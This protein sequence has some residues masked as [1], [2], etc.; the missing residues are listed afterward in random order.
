M[1]SYKFVAL[2]SAL[3]AGVAAAPVSKRM[4]GQSTFYDPSTG[5]G[6][7]G[8]NNNKNEHV[9]AVT[10]S[11]YAGGSN[12]GKHISITNKKTGTVQSA[13]IADECPT[14][15][16]EQDLDMSPGLF[17]SLGGTE[18]EGVFPISWHFNGKQKRASGQATFYDAGLGACGDTNSASDMIVAVTPSMYGGG[19][20]CGK[21]ISIT[22]QKTG[23]TQQATIKDL[24]PTCGGSQDLDMSK[25]LF[26]ALGGTENEG[27][28][29]I[30]W[31]FGGSSSGSSNNNNNNKQNNNNNNKQNGQNKK[32]ASKSDNSGS[33]SSSSSASPSKTSAA[34]SHSASATGTSTS[35]ASAQATGSNNQ[36]SKDTVSGTPSWWAKVESYCNLDSQPENPV[37]IAG[38]RLWSV[39]D[40]SKACGKAVS[41]KNPS[42][43]KT[44][45]G[46]VVSYLP[47]GEENSIALEDAYKQL[48]GDAGSVDSVQWGFTD[49]N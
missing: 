22:N 42:N 28:F 17:K 27:V 46:T 29:P 33:S 49:S 18:N 25:G 8:W 39:A 47:S 12:C 30:T 5:T 20:N 43:G 11:M 48:A 36:G 35:S 21:Q 24:C 10:P 2:A 15:S 34:T 37:A 23:T 45:Q 16:G 44:V 9:V 7:C 3:V 13:M 38:S 41:V 14:C 31:S 32:Q 4:T 1:L 6:A 19:S 40:L 26:K